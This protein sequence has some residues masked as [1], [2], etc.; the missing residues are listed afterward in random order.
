MINRFKQLR[1]EYNEQLKDKNPK[2]KLYSVEDMCEEM[3]NAGFT[4]SKAKIKKIESEQ[5]DVSIDAKT[6]LAYKWKF[7]VS[8]DWLIDNTVQTR[9]VD[10][11]IASASKVIGLSDVAIE[12]ISKLKPDYKM[13][14]DKMIS[15][16]CF[17]LVLPEIRNLLGYNSLKPHIK[18]LF[19]E[20]SYK[21][22]AEIDQFLFDAINDNT[23]STFFNET[24]IKRIKDI[25]DNTMLD[26]D[27]Q[28]YFREK[29]KNSKIGSVLT[30]AD[31][32]K[33]NP[34][35]GKLEYKGSD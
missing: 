31:L 24:V 17:L 7:G 26:K 18:L 30:A 5:P 19:D 27:L 6:L 11:N 32:P 28:A 13:I 14:L 1:E 8:V 20:K 10:G 12:E 23:V 22:G 4:V 3:K 15:N 21:N 25:I 9:K 2:A 29:D 33:H 16:Y 34:E 35:T